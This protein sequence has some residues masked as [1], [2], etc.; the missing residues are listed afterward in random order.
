MYSLLIGRHMQYEFLK[1]ESHDIVL[2]MRADHGHSNV[3]SL[4]Q[5]AALFR[6]GNQAMRPVLSGSGEGAPSAVPISCSENQQ[7]ANWQRMQ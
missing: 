1:Y 4:S 2:P 6:A 3:P 5:H 7:L